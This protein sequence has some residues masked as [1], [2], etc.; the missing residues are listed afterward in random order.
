[1]CDVSYDLTDSDPRPGYMQVANLTWGP[2][3]LDGNFN[4]SV[5]EGYAVFQV[6]PDRS[7]TCNVGNLQHSADLNHVDL[8]YALSVIPKR[9]AQAKALDGMSAACNCHNDIYSVQLSWKLPDDLSSVRLM[10][11]PVTAAGDVL[12]VGLTT[13]IVEDSAASTTARSTAGMSTTIEGSLS[14]DVSNAS[15]FVANPQVKL[16]VAKGIANTAG[17]P[18]EWVD[19]E[20]Q[21]Q[22]RR[23]GSGVRKLQGV[24]TVLVNYAITVPAGAASQGQDTASSVLSSLQSTS[25]AA[26]TAAVT[27]ALNERVGNGA[28]EVVVTAMSPPSVRASGTTTTL[29]QRSGGARA[30]PTGEV[31]DEERKGGFFVVVGIFVSVVTLCICCIIAACV[32]KGRNPP[33]VQVYE[34]NDV[35]SSE[36]NDLRG[37]AAGQDAPPSSFSACQ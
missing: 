19:V 37:A 9:G 15:A 26:M 16:A 3:V 10:I 34:I 20:L 5:I 13:G 21:L 17:V 4:E 28:F 22:R 11:S 32:I 14:M 29:S 25:P 8:Q 7:Q 12:P 35:R 6:D 31:E 23:L 1:V 27:D 24:G 30:I 36:E 33:A 18:A 2:N